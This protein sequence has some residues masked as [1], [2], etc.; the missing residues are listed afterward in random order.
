MY[1]LDVD[2]SRRMGENDSDQ[3]AKVLGTRTVGG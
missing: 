2:D 3:T 1:L